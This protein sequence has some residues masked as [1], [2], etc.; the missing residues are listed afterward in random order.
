MHADG[1][2]FHVQAVLRYVGITN[3]RQIGRYHGELIRQQGNDG[4]PHAR[5]LRIAMQQDHSRAM[6][7]Y[8]VVEFEAVNISDFR[9][10]CFGCSVCVRRQ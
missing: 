7:G 1:R 3:S 8:Q 10:D 9:G 2:G 5:C 4:P 6:A